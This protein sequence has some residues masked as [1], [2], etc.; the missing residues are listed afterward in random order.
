MKHK[1]TFTAAAVMLLSMVSSAASAV[2]YE[3]IMAKISEAREAEAAVIVERENDFRAKLEEQQRLVREATRLRD[4]AEALSGR[5]D[6]Q[7]ADNE[8]TIDDMNTRLQIAQGNL[9]ELFGVTRQIAGDVSGVLSGSLINTQLVTPAGEE[10][11]V[12]F[13]RRVAAATAL[14]SLR[15]L[16]D[17]WLAL[18]TEMK[19]DSEVIRYT[20]PVLQEDGITS[21]PTEVVRVGSFGAIGDGEYLGYLPG[22]NTL[23]KLTRQPPDRWMMNLAEDIQENTSGSGYVPAVVDASHGPLMGLYVERPDV[24]ER[25]ENGEVVGYVIVAVGAIGVVVALLQYL[26]LFYMKFAVSSQLKHINQPQKNNPLGRLLLS[27][28]ETVGDRPEVVELRISEA[29]LREIPKLE[30]FQAFLRLA[31]AAGPLLGLIGTVIGMIITFESITAS[32]SSDPKLMAEGIGQA[33]IATVLGLGI[34][35]PLLFLNAGLV[36]LSRSVVNVLEEQST[37]LLAV[38]L[39]QASH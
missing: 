33:M 34:A 10:N 17:L 4:E 36:S 13:L 28:N 25:I 22:A 38:R 1:S 14:P 8:Q 31:V 15:E 2:T 27:A 6:Q 32:G 24:I 23:F 16:E 5:L 3:E 37:R 19:L 9:G 11:R 35:I 29:V 12:D 21:V 39:E 30:R 18:M 20:T 7:Y 26:Y